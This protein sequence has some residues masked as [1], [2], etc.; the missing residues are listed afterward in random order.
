MRTNS[1]TVGCYYVNLDGEKFANFKK[2]ISKK[3]IFVLDDNFHV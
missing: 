3:Y 1:F 2:T